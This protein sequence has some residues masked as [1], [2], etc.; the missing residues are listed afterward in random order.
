MDLSHPLLLLILNRL[1]GR[2]LDD[3]LHA[4]E[5]YCVTL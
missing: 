1:H 5:T 2:P 4:R 3:P